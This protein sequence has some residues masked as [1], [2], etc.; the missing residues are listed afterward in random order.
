M[1]TNK[2]ITLRI[3]SITLLSVVILAAVLVAV[4]TYFMNSLTNTILLSI[5]QPIAKTAAQSVEGNMHMMGDRFFLIRDNNSLYSRY[6]LTRDKQKV[7]DGVMAG[8][9][10]VWLGLYE[11]DGT[12]LTG[13]DDSPRSIL[14]TT[15]YTLMQGT[16]NLVI[17]DTS[18][19]TGGLEIVMGVP[20]ESARPTEDGKSMEP[21]I[22]YYLAGSYKYDIL[23][24]ALSNIN[25]GASGLAFIINQD[26]NLIAHRDLGKVYSM[27][28][29]VESLGDD[30]SN[31]DV[32]RLMKEGQTGSAELDL[33]GGTAFVS[34][35]PI[36]GTRWSLGIL[37]PRG[38]FMAAVRSALIISVTI[39]AAALAFFTL[40]ISFFLRKILMKP[41]A[42]ITEEAR[43]IALGQF[44]SNLPAELK[45][46][47]D[48]IGTLGAAF[49]HM[50]DSIR[51]VISDIGRLT[52]AARAGSLDDRADAV[53]HLGSYHLIIA[54]INSTL[55]VI[56]SHLNVMPGALALFDGDHRLIFSNDD[57]NDL[58]SRHSAIFDQDHLLA[59]ILSTGE[60]SALPEDASNLFDRDASDLGSYNADVTIQ[61][62]NGEE[63][64]YSIKLRRIG[65]ATGET[66]A[67]EASP[68]CVMLIMSDVS[69]LTKA[70]EG[71]EMASRAK[72]DFLANMSHEIRTPMNAIIG[73]TAVA[74][75]A[76]NIER[77]DYCLGKINDASTHLLG[78]INDILDMSKIEANKFELSFAEFDYEKMLQKVASVINFRVEEK[79]Q[80]FSVHIDDHIPRLLVGDD[81]RLTQVITN[82]LSNSVKFTPEEGAI[83][84]DNKLVKEENGICTIQVDVTDS[85]IGVSEDQQARLFSSFEQADNGISRKFGG[86]G[87][88]LAISKRIVEMMNGTIWIESKLGE[89]SKFSF[90]IQ[91]LRAEDEPQ[92]LLRPGINWS[93]M[94]VL[95]VDDTSDVR[96]YLKEIMDSLG[97][98]C[99]IASS[100]EEAIDLLDKNGNYDIYFV[101]WKMPGIDGIELSRRIKWRG[102]DNVVIMIS[103]AE[104]TLIEDDAKS[105][106]V[107]KFLSKPL[108]ASPIAACI[109]ECL[110]KSNLLASYEEEKQ[111]NESPDLSGRR[112]ILAEDIEINREIVLSFLEST[113]LV[114]DC[115][116]NG[117]E[118]VRIF[119]ESPDRYDLIFMDIQMPEMDGY[120]AAR[121]IRALDIEK[122]Q[123]IPLVAM[124]ANVF[125]E[126]IERCLAA[127]M[128][129]HLGKPLD[130]EH[131]MG[132]LR[133][134]LLDS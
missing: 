87:L 108:F 2:S 28:P 59:G 58:L 39:T 132:K 20:V 84:L 80:I 117:A 26:G 10:F 98:A 40:V 110:G 21:Y 32:M 27:E 125:R 69:Q 33:A 112:I 95:A 54:G 43:R 79:R 42:A 25:V 56:C 75:S 48:E 47:R 115:A 13:S 37:A 83:R 82:L 94:R 122:A 123:Q 70:K 38:D 62:N 44:E 22:A 9:E 23:S 74:K 73:M 133:R 101:D 120:E 52:L 15:L 35:S 78:V 11:T 12:L 36:R 100:G 55:D 14:G 118:A 18:V 129:D 113:N 1:K 60:S 63:F 19:G 91:A 8:I 16:D 127:G 3:L 64:Y 116:V 34:F 24:D 88:G 89:G 66:N 107:S 96:D 97:I 72:S 109:N 29:L 65:N 103:A 31:Q 41:L 17:E 105:A 57:M 50:S 46:R 77:K 111:R 4:M 104:W 45:D 130:L 93:N 68:V 119:S 131:V 81:Q 102:A 134:Y 99:D 71:A 92:D 90:T 30:K 128:N 121:R 49:I 5:L 67:S 85:G 61:G 53:S 76:N 86:T 6:N 114:I 124:T 7:I 106:G 51:R 126:D